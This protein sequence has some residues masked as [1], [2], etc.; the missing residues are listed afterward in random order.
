MIDTAALRAYIPVVDGF[1]EAAALA[2]IANFWRGVLEAAS[3]HVTGQSGVQVESAR[4]ALNSLQAFL[5][6]GMP[7]EQVDS[8]RVQLM[9]PTPCLVPH[10]SLP[11]SS[12]DPST[13]LGLFSL[14]NRQE[15][16]SGAAFA[17]HLPYTLTLLEAVLQGPAIVVSVILEAHPGVDKET[18]QSAAMHATQ[19]LSLL[20]AARVESLCTLAI[21]ATDELFMRMPFI[22][23]IG[24]HDF[25]RFGSRFFG[26]GELEYFKC[27][28]TSGFVIPEDYY[29]QQLYM[30]YGPGIACEEKLKPGSFPDMAIA[31]KAAWQELSLCTSLEGRTR[32]SGVWN[33]FRSIYFDSALKRV[34][35]RGGSFSNIVDVERTGER[36]R[37][38][39][40]YWEGRGLGGAYL[41]DSVSILTHFLMHPGVRVFFARS[42]ESAW[43]RELPEDDPIAPLVAAAPIAAPYLL[44][45]LSDRVCVYTS[46]GEMRAINRG[47]WVN[48]P[49][50]EYLEP[51][52]RAGWELVPFYLLGLESEALR[53]TLDES[54]SRRSHWLSR[55]IHNPTRA[56]FQD[57]RRVQIGPE[58]GTESVRSHAR[59]IVEELLRPNLSTLTKA[60]GRPFLTLQELGAVFGR[61]YDRLRHWV[62]DYNL[63]AYSIQA[64][65]HRFTYEGLRGFVVKELAGRRGFSEE[66][67]SEVL[68]R[69]EE[70]FSSTK[71]VQ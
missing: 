11:G 1:R 30:T 20:G 69:I 32:T 67:V 41:E 65:D 5:S 40:E 68:K 26:Q 38:R 52:D 42:L 57:R 3:R 47:F 18:L 27:G 29:G 15:K 4:K 58:E 43:R 39:A 71:R 37:E 46:R 45:L 33:P 66:K 16:S 61:S 12:S 51:S 28:V 64:H 70:S 34:E 55:L 25:Y 13:P 17:V 23:F 59:R 8:L 35:E 10:G 22:P 63:G 56:M 50:I 7:R 54:G 48:P 44:S 21:R 62:N 60:E 49:V 36:L 24:A 31:G 6:S 9:G 53:T 14:M 19:I 2:P